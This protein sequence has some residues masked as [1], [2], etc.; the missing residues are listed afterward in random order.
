MIACAN[1]CVVDLALMLLSFAPVDLR[2]DV[3][4]YNVLD[5]RWRAKG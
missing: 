4:N 3:I 1:S 2:K 5:L